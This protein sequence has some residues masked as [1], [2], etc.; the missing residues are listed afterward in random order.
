VRAEREYTV[1]SVGEAFYNGELE[2]EL[3]CIG[4]IDYTSSRET[5]TERGAWR[6]LKK[7][8]VQVCTHIWIW[9]VQMI[10]RRE[11]RCRWYILDCVFLSHNLKLGDRRQKDREIVQS[12]EC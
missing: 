3:R 5:V 7:S 10:A 4:K 1:H 12:W 6:L 8:V 2:N 9:I 11:V